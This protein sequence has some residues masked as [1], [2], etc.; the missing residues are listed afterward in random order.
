[1]DKYKFR[2]LHLMTGCNLKCVVLHDHPKSNPPLQ[3]RSLIANQVD[4]D[5]I[6]R[7][8]GEAAAAGDPVA[9]RIKGLKLETN[10]FILLLHDPYEG[11]HIQCENNLLV[12]CRL[13]GPTLSFWWAPRP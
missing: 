2:N 8:V 4:W 6:R 12:D 13:S 7:L 9:A 10:S 5:A 3:V 1:M 11:L